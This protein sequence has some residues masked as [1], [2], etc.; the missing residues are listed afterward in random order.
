VPHFQ[1]MCLLLL[2]LISPPILMM[3]QQHMLSFCC[4]PL[5]TNLLTSINKVPVLYSIYVTRQSHINS[6]KSEADVSF[7]F[8]HTWFSSTIQMAYSKAKLK[9]SGNK[10]LVS[11]HFEKENYQTKVYLYGFNCMFH[12]NTL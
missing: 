12:L 3:R 4:I 11:D 8:S 6:I 2:C 1:I 9:I 7:N 10:L 5:Q